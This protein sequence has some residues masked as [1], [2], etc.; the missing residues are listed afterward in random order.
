MGLT[1]VHITNAYHPASGGIRTFYTALLE[2][3]SRERRRVRLIVPWH[4]TRV[5]D[6][7]EFGKIYFVRAPLAPAFDRRYRLILPWRFLPGVRGPIV[8]ILERERPD[9]VE[10]CDKYSLPYLAAM[11]RKRW[12]PR[13]PRPVL[14]GLT[15]E[16]FDD[17]MAAYVSTSRAARAFTRWYIRNIYGP[18]FDA[19]I[20]NSEYT[21]GELRA[22]LHDR[23]HG[24]IRVAPM[25]VDAD[26]FGPQWRDPDA[27]AGLLAYTG[28]SPTSTLV[29]Y[30]GRVSPEKNTDLLLEMFQLLVRE[31]GAD[32]RL[33]IAGDGPLL[34]RVRHL[35]NERGLASRILLCGNLDRQMLASCYAN[36]DVFVHPN[37]REPFGIGPLEAMASGVPVV[38]PSAGGVLEYASRRNAWLAE[39]TAAAFADAVRSAR[40]G[41]PHRVRAARDTARQFRWADITQR[42]FALCDDIHASWKRRSRPARLP[43]LDAHVIRE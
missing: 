6:V 33:V 27:R 32:Y 31:D 25:G 24:F 23:P 3:A 26:E 11:L 36:A 35:A 20:A 39:P 21:A 1:S 17:N 14:T 15:C 18:P 43:R 9:L 10:I 16:R 42:Y 30:A 41:D 37:P 7:G 13:V 19:H 22:A 29:L 34:P 38:V 12:H 4:E 40:R 2:A 28:G 5:E 8:E